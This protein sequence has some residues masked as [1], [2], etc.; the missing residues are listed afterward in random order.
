MN[1][2]PARR[3]STGSRPTPSQDVSSKATST[4]TTIAPAGKV[5]RTGASTVGT[6]RRTAS[7]PPKS[8]F[9]LR[10]LDIALTLG[11]LLVIAAIVWTGINP[12]TATPTPQ[13]NVAGVPQ[14]AVAPAVQGGPAPDFSL[15]TIDNQT[16]TLS[17]QKGKVVL[18]EF[19]APWCPH[20]QGDVP[21]FNE[22]QTR[23]KDK[24]VD[25]IGVSASSRGID[26]ESPIAMEDLVKFR[27]Q[28][29]VEIPLLFDPS[30]NAANAY[31]VEY[32]PTVY[33]VDKAGN[34]FGKY[35]AAEGAPLTPDSLGA[36][37]DK[38]LQQ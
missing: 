36:E 35:L 2:Q 5:A 21:V 28:F 29:K 10:P 6:A 13:N 14:P 11:L 17:A 9:K 26:N 31:T 23:Y 27:D 8:T 7:T 25:V 4:R 33:I 19:L 22:L 12:G 20:C 3:S 1:K 38:A 30:L 15:P 16:Y 34:I 24:G 18:I 32:Y 37:I